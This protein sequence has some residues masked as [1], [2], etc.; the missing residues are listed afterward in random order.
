[1]TAVFYSEIPA[2][3]I[4][5]GIYFG[6]INKNVKIVEDFN[7][8]SGSNDMVALKDVEKADGIYEV[9]VSF[10]RID[11]VHPRGNFYL[12]KAES[13]KLKQIIRLKLAI[14]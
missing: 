7:I 2:L 5:N 14:F 10:R 13:L 4:V 11:K 12:H 1:M 3:L 9:R 6:E 8:A